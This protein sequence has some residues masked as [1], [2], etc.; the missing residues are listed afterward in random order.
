MQVDAQATLAAIPKLLPQDPE[1]CR[2]AV[3]AIREVI[4]A[5]GEIGPETEARLREV[6][7]LFGG[8]APTGTRST[9][10]VVGGRS[11]KA[12]AS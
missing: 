10:R 11:D 1:A 7:R 6:A 12:K 5:T 3:A 8:D 4:G 2:N 9:P